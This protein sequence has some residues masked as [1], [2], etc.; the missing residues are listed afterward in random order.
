[1]TLTR[2][3]LLIGAGG[4][5]AAA[6][7]PTTAW[8]ATQAVEG[9]AFGSYWR[10]VLPSDADAAAVR[11][12][13]QAVIA[14][15]DDA[16]SPYREASELSRFNSAPAGEW[17]PLSAHCTAVAAEGLRIATLTDGAFDPTVGGIVGRYGFGPIHSEVPA[18][19]RDLMVQNGALKKAKA[20][21]TFDPC[22]I[23]KG[24]ALDLLAAE[25]HG[26]GIDSFMIE[27]GGDVLTRGVHPDGRPWQ[28]GIEQPGGQALAFQRIVRLEG[29]A[30]ATS[31]DAANSYDLAGHR[32]SH[33]IDPR[34]ARPVGG[35]LASVSVV[36]STGMTADA[37]A[38]ALFAMGAGAGTEFARQ[39]GLA[40]LFLL[41]TD[42]GLTEIKTPLLAP[43]ILA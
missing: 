17:F 12:V 27:I 4:M 20:G 9:P 28:I 2:R 13:V 41:R 43:Y 10:V 36:A 29:D 30:L 24:Y 15:V 19:Y 26:L 31:G 16:M 38:T 7:L 22:G 32:F 37:L 14:T 5:A 3:D 42:A 23:G 6:G 11:P 18:A 21:V 40:A 8:A 33:I 35:D 34:T 25:I 1:M 39:Q